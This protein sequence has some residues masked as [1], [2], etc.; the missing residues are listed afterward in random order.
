[1]EEIKNNKILLSVIIPVFNEQ[2]NLSSLYQALKTLLPTVVESY[3]IIFIDDGSSDRSAIEIT[4]LSTVDP[5]VKLIEFSRNFGKE[6]AITAGINMCQGRACIIMDADFQHP[7]EKIPEFIEKWKQG[8]EVV[9]GIRKKTKGQSL[10][11][12]SCS[13][14]FYKILNFISSTAIVENSTDFRLLDRQVIDAFNCFT[15]KNR[16][17]RGLIAWLGFKRDFVYF[18][19]EPRKAGRPGYSFIKL[20]HLA[21]STFVSNSLIPLKLA[22]YLGIFITFVSSLLGSFI[23]VEKYIFNDYFGFH[24]SGPAILAVIN[25]FLIGIVLICL[26][27]IALYIGNIHYEVINRPKYVIRK[28]VQEHTNNL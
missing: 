19:A 8:A 6:M 11:R 4:R 12:N 2:E 27:L 23:L 15:E 24:F 7:I 9:V 1:M 16:M 14:V 13:F 17:T 28:N 25:L 18:D 26:G 20:V 21:M 5:A 3:E 22:G 10:L